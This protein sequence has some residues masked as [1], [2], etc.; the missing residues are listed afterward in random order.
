MQAFAVYSAWA[1]KRNAEVELHGALSGLEAGA[2]SFVGQIADG[3]TLEAIF[4]MTNRVDE[5]DCDYL[6][7]IGY[8][9]PSLSVGDVVK[10]DMR[11]YRCDPVGWTELHD[12]PR[13]TACAEWDEWLDSQASHFLL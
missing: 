2:D 1:R 7:S 9:L 11:W 3:L 4:R 12:V 10:L 8:T 13:M 5:A 6:D